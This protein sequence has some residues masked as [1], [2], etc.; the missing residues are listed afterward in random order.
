MIINGVFK[1]LSNLSL[2]ALIDS[3]GYLS[4]RVVVEVDGMIIKQENFETLWLNGSEKV[5]IVCFVG[6]G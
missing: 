3:Q 4:K 2:N 6:G 5:E 1:E